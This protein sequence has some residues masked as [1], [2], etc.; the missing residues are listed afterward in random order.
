MYIARLASRLILL[1]LVT[2]LAI[3]FFPEGNSRVAEARAT[4]E[5]LPGKS[6]ALT[7]T[8]RQALQ[9]TEQAFPS[10]SAGF[11]AYYRME[12]GGSFSLDKGAVDDHIFSPVEADDT[13]LRS[14][15]ATLVDIGQNYT[16]ATL[17]LKNIDDL[18]STVNLY[19]DDEGWIVA[20]LASGDASALVWQ[21]KGIDVENP[22]VEDIGDTV[23]LAAINVVV[24]DALDETA[25][26]DD[27]SDLGYYHWQF[28]EADNFMMMAVSRKDQGEYPVQFAVPESLTLSEISASLWVS[29]GTNPQA[30]CASVTLDNS[31]LIAKQCAK[32]IYSGTVDLTN[33]ADT[34]GHTWK[35]IHSER[36]EGG[37]GA[38]MIIIYASS[39]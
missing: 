33:L 36:D 35:L 8:A 17:N 13:T 21:A 29:Q 25:I 11:S 22:D 23:L 7:P 26:E 31:D 27:D 34:A 39:S 3:V 37:S 4:V 24:D 10:D 18:G 1:F 32:G 38:L 20:Y 12:E 6:M 5:G 2:A 19:Y 9:E 15:P 28:P 30:P 14:A 16:V